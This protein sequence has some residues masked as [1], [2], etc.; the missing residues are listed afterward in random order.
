MLFCYTLSYDI[1]QFFATE[2]NFFVQDIFVV[3]TNDLKSFMYIARFLPSKFR[4]ADTAMLLSHTVIARLGRCRNVDWIWEQ[5]CDERRFPGKKQNTQFDG[6]KKRT[7]KQMNRIESIITS[8]RHTRLPH[9]FAINCPSYVQKC[10]LI[11]TASLFC[12][13]SLFHFQRNYVTAPIF[14]GGNNVGISFWQK[15]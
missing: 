7:L 15:E 13:R 2:G 6:P 4:P 8:V 3:L 12:L 10:P 5:W 1:I 9:F 11:I 14:R